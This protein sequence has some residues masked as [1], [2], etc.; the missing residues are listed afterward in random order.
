MSSHTLE[1]DREAWHP[2]SNS[3][4]AVCGLGSISWFVTGG[5]DHSSLIGSCETGMQR[6]TLTASYHL[7]FQEDFLN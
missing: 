5:N 6:W 1:L 3:F 4:L 2:D 7:S